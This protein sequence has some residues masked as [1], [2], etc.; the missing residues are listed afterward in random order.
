MN[1]PTRLARR[2]F[3][4]GVVAAS[5]VLAPR[6]ATAETQPR[7]GPP[8]GAGTGP[9]S[10]LDPQIARLRSLRIADEIE[11]ILIRVPGLD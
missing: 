2:N 4:R 5:A 6:E 9:D 3:I 7:Q 1:V 10:Q 11:P 8:Q